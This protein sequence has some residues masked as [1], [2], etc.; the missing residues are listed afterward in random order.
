MN[1][2][3]HKLRTNLFPK[4]N[5]INMDAIRNINSEYSGRIDNT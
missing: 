3:I 2:K 4:E 1:V 5:I